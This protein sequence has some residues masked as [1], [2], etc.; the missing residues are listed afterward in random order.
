MITSVAEQHPALALDFVLSHLNEVN[1]L[2][3]L[4]GR[5]RFVAGLVSQSD[6]VALVPKLEAYGKQTFSAEN[7]KP[8][9]RAV[10]RIRWKAANRDRIRSETAAWLKA[11]PQG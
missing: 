11:H 1:P 5:S 8:I 10:A 2:V 9:E 3:D 7:R 4:S 6:Q